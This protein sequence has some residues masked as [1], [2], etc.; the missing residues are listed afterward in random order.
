MD[1]EYSPA[2][3]WYQDDEPMGR[4]GYKTEFVRPV[5]INRTDHGMG[6]AVNMVTGVSQPYHSDLERDFIWWASLIP[7]LVSLKAQP[8][9]FTYET[10][11]GPREYTPDF[12]LEFSDRRDL[13]VEVKPSKFLA[14]PEL[15]ARL[16]L[17]KPAIEQAGADFQC[18]TETV[19]RREPRY[20]NICVLQHY[21]SF[22]PPV[23]LARL[24]EF[25]FSKRDEIPMSDLRAIA[26]DSLLLR[27]SVRSLILR[28]W[29]VTDLDQPLSDQ[30]VIRLNFRPN[31]KR[32]NG[33]VQ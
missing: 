14:G 24:I 25:E 4:A 20:N 3:S 2:S 18:I 27:D 29:L 12:H 9:T 33:S 19:L 13:Y 23:K 1:S 16:A 15:R 10:D 21:R 17:I 6:W 28:R 7:N 11:D 8:T 26:E 5:G 22:R 30:S 32:S 31:P